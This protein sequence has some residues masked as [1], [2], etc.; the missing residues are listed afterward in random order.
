MNKSVPESDLEIKKLFPEN[1]KTGSICDMYSW[2]GSRKQLCKVSNSIN[3]ASECISSSS[4]KYVN[5]C[6]VMNP[7]YCEWFYGSPVICV[8]SE[9]SGTLMPGDCGLQGFFNVISLDKHMQWIK[10]VTGGVA[11]LKGSLLKAFMFWLI[12][13][14]CLNH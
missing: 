12:Y 9:V 3:N 10:D 8:G 2:G 7:S 13:F 14:Y 4:T 11:S 5:H 1:L 6:A